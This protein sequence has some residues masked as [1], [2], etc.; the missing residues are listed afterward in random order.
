MLRIKPILCIGICIFVFTTL[1]SQVILPKNKPLGHHG[2][3]E[4]Q[5]NIRQSPK[6]LCFHQ[7]E[8][9]CRSVD[10]TQTTPNSKLLPLNISFTPLLSPVITSEKIRSV[11]QTNMLKIDM[12]T[13]GLYS[14]R[15]PVKER[16]ILGSQFAEKGPV[17]L[18]LWL[19][20][21]K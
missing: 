10:H 6:I 18:V 9:G 15:D 1:T 3:R 13:P 8:S 17:V 19:L 5:M 7:Y 2:I 20:E 16:L 21:L 4:K 12:Y 14:T 11:M